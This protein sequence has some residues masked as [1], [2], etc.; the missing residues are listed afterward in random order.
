[1]LEQSRLQRRVN[2]RHA[3]QLMVE[4]KARVGRDQQA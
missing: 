2:G 3:R 1:M 4:L